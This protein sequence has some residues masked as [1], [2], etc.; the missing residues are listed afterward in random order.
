[1]IINLDEFVAWM[2]LFK[3]VIELHGFVRGQGGECD[4]VWNMKWEWCCFDFLIE[5][6][7]L[8]LPIFIL[9]CKMVTNWLGFII[10]E[11]D[12]V[13]WNWVKFVCFGGSHLFVISVTNL[14]LK[15]AALFYFHIKNDTAEVY[16]MYYISNESLN[17]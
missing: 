11:V 1:M 10:F 3:V 2:T 16:F 5:F 9:K 15:L 6:I 4:G 17:G 8:R 13:E 14:S 12:F 7:I